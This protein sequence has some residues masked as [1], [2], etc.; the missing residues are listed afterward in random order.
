MAT[1]Y[2]GLRQRSD[3]KTDASG[4]LI[5]GTW[6]VNFRPTPGGKSVWKT[7]RAKGPAEAYLERAKL[8]V[9]AAKAPTLDFAE[10][11]ARE[12]LT[13]DSIWPIL[14]RNITADGL[15]HKTLLSLKKVYNRVF[16]EFRLKKYPHIKSP[17]TLSLAFFL[18]YKSYYGV[19]LKRPKGLRAEIQRIKMLIYRLRNFRYVT[20][21]LM[22]ELERF[23]TPEGN[24]KPY[25]DITPTQIRAFL[26]RIKTERPDIYGVTYFMLRTGR[27]VEETTLIERKDIVWDCTSA[28]NPV[29]I[30]IRA[31]TTKMRREAPLNYLDTELQAHIRAYYQISNKHKPANLF[32]NQ[33][34]KK[35]NQRTITRYLGAVS[36]EMF[37]VRLTSHY[38][39]HR[40]CT[41]TCKAKLPMVDIL[42]ISGIKNIATLINN[43]CHSSQEGQASVLER[44][45]L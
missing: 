32:L 41:E 25:P 28:P 14:E 9:E 29:T 5:P 36:Y 30:N 19:E 35:L 16:N 23:E 3:N 38:F 7:V 22:R 1:K 6:N 18:E 37:K 15:T 2:I 44:T 31:E 43:Y 4:K 8:M 40:F 45:R 27:R 11:M 13:F 24:K 26:A 33:Q 10:G 12:E 39:R 20:E 34:N 21:D 17:A 42:K